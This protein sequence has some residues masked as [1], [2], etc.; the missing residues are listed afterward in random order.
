MSLFE[1]GPFTLPSG[2]AT[3]FKIE[4]DVLTEN[5]WGALARLAAAIMPPFGK[6]EGVPR[7]GIAFAT[8]LEKYI[9]PHSQRLVIADDVWVTGLSMNRYRQQHAEEHDALGIRDIMGVV[10]F[11]RGVLDPWVRTLFLMHAH[12]EAATYQLNY[13]YGVVP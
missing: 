9:T 13:P 2:R 7:G 1:L 6:V 3:H 5:D 8:A 4:C 12:A 10:A 11:S